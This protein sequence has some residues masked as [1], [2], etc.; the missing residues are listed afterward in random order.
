MFTIPFGRRAFAPLFVVTS[1]TFALGL[2]TA[3]AAAQSGSGLLAAWGKNASGQ[4]MIPASL[5]ECIQIEAGMGHTVAIKVNG[6]VAAWGENLQGQI[7]VPSGLG[8]CTKV[9]AGGQHT[10]AL[11]QNG[12]VIAWGAGTTHGAFPHRGQ[13]IVPAK[14]GTCVQI[15]AGNYHTL[16]IRQSGSVAAWGEGEESVVPA[17]V[18]NC[19]RV[20]GGH[21]HSIVIKQ[22]GSVFAW[23]LNGSNQC[24]I[25]SNL[26]PCSEI[27]A[28]DHFTLALQLNGTVRKWGGL[29]APLPTNLGPCTK[30]AAGAQLAMALTQDGFVRVWGDSTCCGQ[31]NV[32]TT[33][34]ACQQIAV[35]WE[36]VVTIKDA[37]QRL[38]PLQYAT[39]QAAVDAAVN[40]DA[41]RISPGVYYERVLI[42]GKSI[43]LQGNH[44][45]SAA[46]V[47]NNAGMSASVVYVGP[48]ALSFAMRDLTLTHGGVVQSNGSGIFCQM[49]LASPPTLIE[50]CIFRDN[51]SSGTYS[52]GGGEFYGR[53]ILRD[54]LFINNKAGVWGHGFY[55]GDGGD[56]TI[57][58][59][60][61]RD[62]PYNLIY[63]RN[64]AV[65]QVA[66]SVIKNS[67]ELCAHTT[68]TISFANSSGC[69]IG[70]MGGGYIDG[71]GNNWNSCPDCNSNGV[72]DLEEILLGSVVDAD[73]NNIPDSCECDGDV[74]STGTI[75][76]VDLAAMLSEWGTPGSLYPRADV[77]N[78]GTVNGMDLAYILNGWGNCP[79]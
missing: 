24:D 33:L 74:V 48:T 35:G 55:V 18:G 42:E 66:N 6:T 76:G 17:T 19:M 22:D 63:A 53:V 47:I 68:G 79:N 44:G 65:V 41:V 72:L 78:D 3:S 49:S 32:P 62:H 60:V 54:C 23:G 51:L 12:T 64:G 1:T 31:L 29:F 5:G 45:Q 69:Q 9:A 50:R 56:V 26:G 7:N 43:A 58:S 52:A 70:S 59:C 67:V 2:L 71:G 40:G 21:A 75:D 34:G 8:V 73:D 11:N 28:G 27:A 10:V 20:A 57:E 13:S 4:T 15:A 37:S 77:N 46:T 16:A 14:L 25:P 61:F 38:V 30:I 39:I 36:H